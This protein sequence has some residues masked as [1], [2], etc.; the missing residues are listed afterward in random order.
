MDYEFVE[1]DYEYADDEGDEN[2]YLV[3][4]D[5]Y[6]DPG[7]YPDPLLIAAVTCVFCLIVFGALTKFTVYVFGSVPP[8][9]LAGRKLPN[10]NRILRHKLILHPGMANARSAHNIRKKSLAG[11]V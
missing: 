1:D 8:S 4:G 3:E 10:R 9:E 2:I 5:F 7:L 11:V 6:E